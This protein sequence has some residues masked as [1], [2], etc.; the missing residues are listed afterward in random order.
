MIGYFNFNKMNKIEDKLYKE[1]KKE[2]L[3][4][5][6]RNPTL[7]PDAAFVAWFIKA[8]ITDDEVKAVN[9]LYGRANDKNADAIYFD[10]K[11]RIVF[12]IQGKYNQSIN[13]KHEKGNDVAA[14][15]NLGRAILLEEDGLFKKLMLSASVAVRKQLTEARHLVQSRGYIL[16][17]QFITTGKVSRSIIDE[18]ETVIDDWDQAYIN[19]YNGDDILLLCQQYLDG[20]A[21]PPP[22]IRLPL[23]S[24]QHIERHDEVTGNISWILTMNGASIGKVYN[25]I[26]RRLFARNIRGFLGKNEI[27]KNI[28]KTLKNE[29]HL[30]WYYNNG[31]TIIGNKVK[32]ESSG[33]ESYISLQNAQIINGQ[34]TTRILGN[35]SGKEAKVLVRIIEIPCQPE[36]SALD[37]MVGHIV[38]ATNYQNQITASDLKSND[39]EQIR[40]EREIRKMN[41]LY[42][43]K[44]A[45]AE[46]IS[47]MNVDKYPWKVWKDRLAKTIAACVLDPYI[48]RVGGKNKLFS[49]DVYRHLFNGKSVKSYLTFYWLDKLMNQLTQKDTRRYYAHWLIL[50]FLWQMTEKYFSDNQTQKAFIYLSERHLQNKYKKVL[51]HLLNV[52]EKGYIASMAFYRSNK[53][54]SGKITDVSSFFK[55]PN[56]VKK[57][58]NYWLRQY[59]KENAYTRK[60][61]KDFFNKLSKVSLGN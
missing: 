14:L 35:Y 5:I 10:H 38:K 7:S 6:D 53:E 4:I 32:L 29:P 46:E 3:E 58:N 54:K 33:G 43:R 22:A 55:Q 60:N 39:L 26:G 21:P 9:A 47:E 37:K 41:Y 48:V 8:F 16:H 45:S 34:Q 44:R 52:C 27:N 2:N 23:D 51:R 20:I 40:I 49:D 42:I 61:I 56:L 30:F 24:E 28:E 31:I 17:L 11:T 59:K 1:L 50:N 15:A 18:A 57:F 25:D 13:K 36:D 12:I 19:I